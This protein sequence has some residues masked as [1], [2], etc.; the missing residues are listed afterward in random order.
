[1]RRRKLL[2][3]SGAL[4]ATATIGTAGASEDQQIGLQTV[5]LEDRV[6]ELIQDGNVAEAQAIMDDHGIEYD[7][8]S[9]AIQNSSHGGE[10]GEIGIQSRYRNN[11][12]YDVGILPHGDGENVYY[13]FD[14]ITFNERVYSLRDASIIDD[15]M[16]ISWADSD[17][18]GTTPDEDGVNYWSDSVA[19]SVSHEDYVPGR[20][21]AGAV[22][23]DRDYDGGTVGMGVKLD[24]IRDGAD[25]VQFE[26]EHTWDGFNTPGDIGNV[27]IGVSYG[28]LS[29]S[30]PAD[31][32]TAWSHEEAA[33]L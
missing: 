10:N 2:K 13:A 26:Y 14:N 18:T 33:T 6:I 21:V 11:A 8:N 32:S 5:G 7:I 9:G 3:A 30:L 16:G 17:W 12:D 23:L 27:S 4:L 22:E 15:G 1:M 29:V 28:G 31:G 19:D 20:G 24:K 25:S